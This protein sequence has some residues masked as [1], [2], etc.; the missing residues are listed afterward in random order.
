MEMAIL[1]ST[2]FVELF[3]HQK[4]LENSITKEES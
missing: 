3:F 2:S 4:Q 1:N